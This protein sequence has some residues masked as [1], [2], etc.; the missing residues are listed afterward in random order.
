MAVHVYDPGM[1]S[2]LM[3][4]VCEFS[5]KK[6]DFQVLFWTLLNNTCLKK[7]VH[8]NFRGFMAEDASAN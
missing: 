3:I 4:V 8:V 7:G 2:L 5:N 6:H 1:R